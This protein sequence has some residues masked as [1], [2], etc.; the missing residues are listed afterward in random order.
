MASSTRIFSFGLGATPSRSL[1]KGLA[2]TTNGRA[3]FIP[4]NTNIEEYVS[5]QL[6]KAVRRCVTNVRVQ[7]N[8]GI[9]VESIPNQ[10]PQAYLNDRLIVYALANNQSIL[11][12]SK[13]SIEIR[14]DQSYYR[15][16]IADSDRIRTTN[17]MIERLAAKALIVQ[18]EHNKYPSTNSKTVRF[19]HIDNGS[20]FAENQILGTKQQRKQR[21]IDLSLKYNI[22]SPY[23]VFVGI[24]K[25]LTRITSHEIPITTSVQS[26]IYTVDRPIEDSMPALRYTTST[27]FDTSLLQDTH[28][29][30]HENIASTNSISVIDHLIQNQNTDGLWYFASNNELI[31]DLTGKPLAAF[32]TSDPYYDESI[33]VAAIIVVQL[34]LE[35]AALR[36]IWED[37]V[38]KARRRLID[39]LH[40]NWKE[41]VILFRD[42]RMTL[43]Q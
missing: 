36:S 15:L 7:W 31:E 3:V 18:L 17:Q 14:T 19:Q 10:L 28:A 29:D 4:P 20:D 38:E 12:T 5:E 30:Q 32:K 6:Q 40:N 16:N 41:I 33:V 24:E 2:R 25:H 43:N 11:L 23:T 37:M 21:I 26:L 13:S 34:E 42:I 8:L 39:L 1:I 9:G 27:R 22:L 35:F